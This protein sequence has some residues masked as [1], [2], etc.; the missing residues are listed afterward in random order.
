MVDVKWRKREKKKRTRG[1][2]S[3]VEVK[4]SDQR[5]LQIGSKEAKL[6]LLEWCITKK[7]EGAADEGEKR[8]TKITNAT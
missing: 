1:I 7:D 8:K 2:N 4:C 3:L 6:N 5:P